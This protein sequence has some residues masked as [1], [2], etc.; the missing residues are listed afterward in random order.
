MP[1]RLVPSL[2]HLNKMSKLYCE[3]SIRVPQS[4]ANELL[5]LEG[6]EAEMLLTAGGHQPTLEDWSLTPAGLD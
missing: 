4:F 5:Y 3:V 2:T 6:D 1:L